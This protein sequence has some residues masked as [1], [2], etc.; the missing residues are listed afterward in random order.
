MFDATGAYEMIG[1]L[2]DIGG[3]IPDNDHFEAVIVVQMYMKG[4]KN[5]GRMIVLEVGQPLG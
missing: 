2:A 1:K 3:G 5:G 4:R